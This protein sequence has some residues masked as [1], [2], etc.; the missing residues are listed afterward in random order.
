MFIHFR[1][2]YHNPFLGDNC[3][4]ARR[5]ASLLLP[6]RNP[7]SVPAGTLPSIATFSFKITAPLIPKLVMRHGHE[8]IPATSRP[9][10]EKHL[11]IATKRLVSEAEVPACLLPKLVMGRDTG[12]I[13]SNLI[14]KLVMR[15]EHESIPTT[16]RPN[17]EKHLLNATKRLVS[18]AEVPA[19]LLPKL[20]MGRDTGPITSN[21][22]SILSRCSLR[23]R[24]PTL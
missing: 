1:S 17:I 6:K 10:I 3:G 18:E 11:L 7:E 16:S 12:P 22:N 5:T 8:S 19:C 23:V 15:H 13:T 4:S 14:P 9:N 20:V 24:Y 21:T 2:Q